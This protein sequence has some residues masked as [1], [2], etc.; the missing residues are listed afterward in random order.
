MTAVAVN[1]AKAGEHKPVM[2]STT[3]TCNRNFIALRT[4][5]QGRSRL[6]DERLEEPWQQP[7][8]RARLLQLIYAEFCIV[9][10]IGRTN[11]LTAACRSSG[12]AIRDNRLSAY[13]ECSQKS[14]QVFYMFTWAAKYCS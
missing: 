4:P 1:C 9:W 7:S 8:R 2:A 3:A 14:R 5:L 6:S 12:L 10:L 13:Q 11:Q